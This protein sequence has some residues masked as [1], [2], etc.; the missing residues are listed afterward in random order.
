M[1]GLMFGIAISF[2]NAVVSRTLADR[3][4]TTYSLQIGHRLFIS[5]SMIDNCLGDV[6]TLPMANMLQGVLPHA[7]P[8]SEKEIVL[9]MTRHGP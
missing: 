4:L 6:L 1:T 8:I 9:Q 3:T 5:R 2:N 7:I